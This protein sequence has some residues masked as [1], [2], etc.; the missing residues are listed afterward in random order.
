MDSH[1][2]T[3]LITVAAGLPGYFLTHALTLT[4]IVLTRQKQTHVL[5]MRCKSRLVVTIVTT[6]YFGHRFAMLEY[7]FGLP[8][9]GVFP[10]DQIPKVW[11]KPTAFIFKTDGHKKSGAHWVSIY[12]DQSGSCFYFDSFG[13]PPLV[14]NHINRIR[15]N[16]TRLRWNVKQLQSATSDVCGQYCLMFL[17]YMSSG[18]G[19]SKF[20]QNF[21]SD[22]KTNDFIVRNFKH[23]KT[24]DKGFVG[25]G[26]GMYSIRCLQNANSKLSLI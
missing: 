5:G 19:I 8:W 20:L 6:G 18:F 22:L 21:S 24:A 3:R 23:R 11:T 17:H 10:A 2:S 16:C 26:R 13:S 15:K 9:I 25:Y 1:F 4:F 14:P 7:L 12:V